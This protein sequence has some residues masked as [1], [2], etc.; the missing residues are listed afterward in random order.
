MPFTTKTFCTDCDQE[1][2]SIHDHDCPNDPMK[3]PVKRAEAEAWQDAFDRNKAAWDKWEEETG[4]LKMCYPSV[5]QYP[6]EIAHEG[7]CILVDD[8]ED[9]DGDGEHGPFISDVLDTP[10]WGDVAR[11]FD[12]AIERTGDTHH[13]FMEGLYDFTGRFGSPELKALVKSANVEEGVTILQFA[14]GS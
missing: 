14:T 1:V 6:H 2:T 4:A 12:D 3:D 11:V 8:G 5:N 7:R 9:Y 10:T 13:I